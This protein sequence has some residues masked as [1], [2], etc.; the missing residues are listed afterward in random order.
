MEEEGLKEIIGL[1]NDTFYYP[2]YQDWCGFFPKESMKMALPLQFQLPNKNLLNM[3][4]PNRIRTHFSM[5][6]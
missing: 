5:I 4:A 6:P 1:D 3:A 2:D